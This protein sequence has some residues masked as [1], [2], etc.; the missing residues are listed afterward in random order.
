MARRLFRFHNGTSRPG[1]P[2]NRMLATGDNF[3]LRYTSAKPAFKIKIRIF[4]IPSNTKYCLE[5]RKMSFFQCSYPLIKGNVNE[6]MAD[7][8][9]NQFRN[10]VKR[11][12]LHYLLS[13]TNCGS[14]LI[15][16]STSTTGL[17]LQ[18]KKHKGLIY[19]K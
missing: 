11:I 2:S 15:L 4:G 13:F 10:L 7:A 12:S 18:Y 17:D 8:S 3:V 19:S 5:Q 1:P 14:A 9:K 6:I 16:L